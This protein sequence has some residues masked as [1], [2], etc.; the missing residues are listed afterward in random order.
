MLHSKM[1]PLWMKDQGC[2][3]AKFLAGKVCVAVV[4]K[5]TRIPKGLLWVCLSSFCNSL[6]FGG[7]MGNYG[8]L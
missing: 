4:G 6:I 5:F 1:G 2:A 3:P 7:I 8:G